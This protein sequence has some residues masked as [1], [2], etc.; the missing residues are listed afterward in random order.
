MTK[1]VSGKRGSILDMTVNDQ[2]AVVKA[3][4]PV[5]EML[6]WGSDLRSA[7]GGR[8]TSSLVDQMFEKYL[9]MFFFV[10][11]GIFK[12]SGELLIACFAGYPGKIGVAVAGL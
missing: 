4:L 8:G 3:K 1:L 12:D 6:G 5:M 2:G 11:G 9:S 7:T 10:V